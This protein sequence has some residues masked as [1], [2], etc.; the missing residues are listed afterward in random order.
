MFNLIAFS[1]FAYNLDFIT[2]TDTYVQDD[3]FDNV[4]VPKGSIVKY[5][6]AKFFPST[7]KRI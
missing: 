7:Y 5:K 6:G 4:F 2:N 3:N 1:L